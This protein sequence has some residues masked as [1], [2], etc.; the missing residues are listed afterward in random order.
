MKTPDFTD[1]NILARDD[2]KATTYKVVAMRRA[3]SRTEE[4]EEFSERFETLEHVVGR[5]ME[6]LDVNRSPRLHSTLLVYM[7]TV[8]EQTGPSGKNREVKKEVKSHLPMK[9][10]SLLNDRLPG[11]SVTTIEEGGQLIGYRSLGPELSTL[12][13]ILNLGLAA[14]R[15]GDTYDAVQAKAMKDMEP[16]ITY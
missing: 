10:Q 15:R 11:S 1:Y 12:I 16:P 3:F 8:V 9:L 14:R 13:T 6:T 7:E 5:I 4:F 2:G